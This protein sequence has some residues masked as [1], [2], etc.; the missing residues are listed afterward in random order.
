MANESGNAIRFIDSVLSHCAGLSQKRFFAIVDSASTD[1]TR[2]VLDQH[3]TVQPELTV[4]WAP[5]NRG[6]VDAY[7]RGY[8]E[9]LDTT[10]D[11]ILEIDAGFSHQPSEISVLLEKMRHGYDCIFGSRF[12]PGGSMMASP[13][14]RQ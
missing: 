7:E 14:T 2:K 11:W 1:D 4:I 5:E 13:L 9:A 10:A 3:A 8:R 6:V 12:C